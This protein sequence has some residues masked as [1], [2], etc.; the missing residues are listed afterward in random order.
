MQPGTVKTL[1]EAQESVQRTRLLSIQG[2]KSESCV[3]IQ[4]E[5]KRSEIRP[6][7]S[8]SSPAAMQMY[9]SSIFMF[10]KASNIDNTVP[11]AEPFPRA[12]RNLKSASSS[13]SFKSALDE[14]EPDIEIV[15]EVEGVLHAFRTALEVL[16]KAMRRIDEEDKGLRVEADMLNL[17]L[18]NGLKIEQTHRYEEVLLF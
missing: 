8:E 4:V 15:R 1:I 3:Q 7:D 16:Q 14:Q 13:K 5:E 18:T 6:I 12:A 11:N 9:G 2:R 17:S 10:Q